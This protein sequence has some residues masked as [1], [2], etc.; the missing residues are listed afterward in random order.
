[1][2]K[3]IHFYNLYKDVLFSNIKLNKFNKKTAQ[4]YKFYFQWYGNNFS[5][6]LMTGGR[7]ALYFITS[8]FINIQYWIVL[9]DPSRSTIV[10]K[11]H[12]CKVSSIP[13]G[14]CPVGFQILVLI[15]EGVFLQMIQIIC[16]LKSKSKWGY[17]INE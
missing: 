9:Q 2:S 6:M 17:K 10:A 7:S 11:N 3:L 14:L 8:I 1:M 4:L 13:S 5:G 15:S 16:G 12:F